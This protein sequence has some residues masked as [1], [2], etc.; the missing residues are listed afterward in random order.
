MNWPMCDPN[1][2]P[3][4]SKRRAKY[5]ISTRM[6]KPSSKRPSTATSTPNDQS[7]KNKDAHQDPTRRDS[8]GFSNP[9]RKKLSPMRLFI[10]LTLF[11]SIVHAGNYHYN[12][13]FTQDQQH[14]VVFKELGLM[15]NPSNLCDAWMENNTNLAESVTNDLNSDHRSNSWPLNETQ[16]LFKN[17]PSVELSNLEAAL[18]T[19]DP[20]A[21]I[22]KDTCHQKNETINRMRRMKRAVTIGILGSLG[23]TFS[24]INFLIPILEPFQNIM[25]EPYTDCF[26]FSLSHGSSTMSL[27]FHKIRTNKSWQS[28][29]ITSQS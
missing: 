7:F 16:T 20:I 4:N 26:N 10:Q 5:K 3:R 22:L 21:K 8:G 17:L 18:F 2:G 29:S 25:S 11:C 27:C 24:P 1:Y 13:P 6:N 14:L 28:P 19:M 15:F 9:R 12:Q 23:G